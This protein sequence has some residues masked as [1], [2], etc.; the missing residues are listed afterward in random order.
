MILIACSARTHGETVER[1]TRAYTYRRAYT[2]IDS[3][4]KTYSTYTIKRPMS[5]CVFVAVSHSSHTVE[6]S[7]SHTVESHVNESHANQPH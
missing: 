5:L 2:E 3:T 4:Q 6:S 1:H 7:E